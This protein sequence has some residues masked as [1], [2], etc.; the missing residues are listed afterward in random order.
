VTYEGDGLWLRAGLS[1][2]MMRPLEATPVNDA[3]QRRGTIALLAYGPARAYSGNAP[4][5]GG[6]LGLGGAQGQLEIFGYLGTL[7]AAEGTDA[8]RNRISGFALLPGFNGDDP[9]RQE[10]AAWW[11]G[12]RAEWGLLGAR[13]RVEGIRSRESLL[14]RHLLAAQLD[15]VWDRPEDA[16]PAT[17]EARVRA[18][19]YVI[20]GA[21][22]ALTP[23]RSLRSPDPSQA[24]SWDHEVLT[25]ALAT[26]LYRR[27]LWLRAEHS[28]IEEDNGAPDLERAHV[29]IANHETTLDLEL[30]F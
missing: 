19:R 10:T 25:V 27:L 30:R 5:F 13:L 14:F 12:A 20:E 8:L 18:E 11:G 2:A 4:I 21:G 9:H 22:D 16:F 26:Q 28:F 6:K 29:P 24:L 1:A 7:A 15:Y 17:L 23:D 3:V